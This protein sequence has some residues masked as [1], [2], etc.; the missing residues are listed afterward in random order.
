MSDFKIVKCKK[1]DAALTQL[2]DEVL[3]SC[4]Q[5]GYKFPLVNKAQKGNIKSVLKNKTA[6]PEVLDMVGKLKQIKATKMSNA[7]PEVADMVRKLRQKAAT[8]TT[9]PKARKTKVVISP[10]KKSNPIG[11]IIFWI[12][13]ISIIKGVFSN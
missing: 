5:C 8:K 1:C 9:Q 4:V 3:T 2:E 11:T 12:I 10:K 7:T 6:T 13:L